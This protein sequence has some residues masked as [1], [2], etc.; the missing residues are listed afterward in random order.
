MNTT[1]YMFCK[2]DDI[3]KWQMF[4]IFVYTC[5]FFSMPVSYFNLQSIWKRER[6]T[7]S[8]IKVIKTDHPHNNNTNLFLCMNI[9]Y[10]SYFRYTLVEKIKG[11]ITCFVFPLRDEQV[12]SHLTLNKQAGIQ[13]FNNYIIK[14][15]RG[16]CIKTSRTRY[17]LFDC[18]ST[19]NYNY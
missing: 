2:P 14:Y 13:F 15:E 6:R 16:Q 11:F 10:L 5:T 1:L 9:G 3:S 7:Q 8:E 18:C 17:D 4:R 12:E 19:V